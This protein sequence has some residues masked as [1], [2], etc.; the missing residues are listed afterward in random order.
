MCQQF[1]PHS[2]TKAFEQVFQQFSSEPTSGG[3]LGGEP[4]PA[5]LSSA[6]SAYRSH[7]GS[8]RA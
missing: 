8:S 4:L 2:T 5:A 7:R 1:E 3:F 6:A